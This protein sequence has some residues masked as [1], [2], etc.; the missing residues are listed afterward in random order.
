MCIIYAGRFVKYSSI[1]ICKLCHLFLFYKLLHYVMLEIL[2]SSSVD[3]CTKMMKPSY[4]KT[5]L[6]KSS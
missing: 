6:M 4:F 2:A 5:V 3:K 1:A